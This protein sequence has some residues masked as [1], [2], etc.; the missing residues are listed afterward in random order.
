MTQDKNTA[1]YAKADCTRSHQEL[2]LRVFL[3]LNRI[4]YYNKIC[5]YLYLKYIN[6]S[7]PYQK[8]KNV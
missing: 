3:Q 2:Q 6:I 5:F 1:N 8:F 4:I 7:K